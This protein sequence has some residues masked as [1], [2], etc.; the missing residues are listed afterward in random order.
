MD[1]LIMIKYLIDTYA[2]VSARKRYAKRSQ[3]I[4]LSSV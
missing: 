2:L 1:V 3:M 4:R